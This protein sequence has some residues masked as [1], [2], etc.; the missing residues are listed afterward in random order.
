MARTRSENSKHERI[1]FRIT[2][3]QKLMFQEIAKQKNI[4]LTELILDSLVKNK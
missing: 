1:I 3:T 2:K 4:S